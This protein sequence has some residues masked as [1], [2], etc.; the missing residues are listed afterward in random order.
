M[1]LEKYFKPVERT[2]FE[3]HYADVELAAM[4]RTEEFPSETKKR[5]AQEWK[6]L[7]FQRATLNHIQWFQLYPES[8]AQGR[9]GPE[10]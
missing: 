3:A 5:H 6:T 8:R 9:E 4:G 2:F 7:R 1:I 10:R